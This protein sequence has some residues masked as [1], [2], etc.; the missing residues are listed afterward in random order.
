MFENGFSFDDS[1][2]IFGRNLTEENFLKDDY[3]QKSKKIIENEGYS[4]YIFGPGSIAEK[5]FNCLIVFYEGLIF[6]LNINMLHE[7]DK[8]FDANDFSE[9]KLAYY[10]KNNDEFLVKLFN[11]KPP[12][13]YPWG[14]VE[15]VVDKKSY[16]TTIL[17]AYSNS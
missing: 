8:G 11:K 7:Y 2:L 1:K 12:Y 14:K 10:K 9:E 3:G 4:T 16:S 17:I 13:V 5:K 15:S 6:S